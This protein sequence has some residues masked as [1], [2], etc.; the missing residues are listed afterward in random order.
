MAFWLGACTTGP[1]HPGGATSTH[2]LAP[3][4]SPVGVVVSPVLSSVL[5][6]VLVVSDPSEVIDSSD[7]C[8]VSVLS[9]LC[10]VSSLDSPT[11][12][13]PVGVVVELVC[14]VESLVD[15]DV[16]VVCE[17]SVT[18]ALV[19]P[20]VCVV[21]A[22]AVVS[23]PSSAVGSKHPVCTAQIKASPTDAAIRWLARH[24]GGVFSVLLD[25]TTRVP[26]HGRAK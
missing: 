17:P 9:E 21:V 10:W 8:V 12:D 26:S 18:V 2:A 3:A 14:V 1:F 15:V 6:V 22:V 16:D 19:V 5:C 11:S 4:H 25:I 20:S 23:M 24:E 7:A 13:V